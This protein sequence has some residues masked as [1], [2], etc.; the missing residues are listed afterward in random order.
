MKQLATEENSNTA[1]I[2]MDY[3]ENFICLY[4]V[5][6]AS[7]HQKTNSVTLFTVIL[8]QK[9]SISMVIVPDNK[10]HDKSTVV[11]Y[12]FTVFNY[13]KEIFGENI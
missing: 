2:Q 8:C 13:V 4:Q 9:E 1:M 6:V 7:A 5:E 12:L 11:P 10:H 3:A